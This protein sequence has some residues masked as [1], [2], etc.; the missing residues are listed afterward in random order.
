MTGIFTREAQISRL[1]SDDEPWDIVVIGGGATGVGVAADA[2]AR[3]YRV[4]LLEHYDFGKGTSS[5]ST[6]LVHGGLRYLKQGRIRLVRDALIERGLLC[7]NAPHLVYPL[8]TIVPLHS[9]WESLY[10]GIGLKVYERLSGRLSLGPSQR[11]SLDEMRRAIPTLE[12]RGLYG[13][14]RYLDGAFDDARLLVNLMQTAIEHGALCANY[15]PA[16]EL[17]KESG[18]VRGVVAEDLET[19]KATQLRAR[20]VVNA[21]GPFSDRILKLD[22]PSAR[23]VIAA[24]QGIHLVFD[25]EFLP[26]D[27]AIIVPKTRDGRVIF[28]VPWHEHAV[29]GTTDTPRADMPLE[30]RPLPG[31]VE[32]ILETI[33]PYLTHKPQMADIRSIFA[34]IRP[35]VRG[36]DASNTSKLGRDHEVRIAASELISV[37]GGKWTTYRKMAE[38]CVD[39]AARVAGLEKRA[40]TTKSMPVHGH[41]NHAPECRL[42]EYGSDAKALEQVIASIPSGNARLAERLPYVAGQVVFAARNEMARTVEDVLARRTRALFLDAEAAV[43][44]APRVAE[45]LAAELGRNAGWQTQQ[46]TQFL[47]VATAY[48]PQFSAALGEPRA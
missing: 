31:E 43:A 3:G 13:G 27:S 41:C 26:S 34:G 12:T 9:R 32:F 7:R 38:D 16:R 22:D 37:L 8:P 39:Q 44:A 25:R 15:A 30:P 21:T 47:D 18:K 5:R 4:A 28:A 11:L 48:R 29:I 36:G 17:I 24:S 14:A 35:L 40:C 10:Y 19:G 23:P 20:V 33:S 42:H 1:E 6:K 2:A 46:L 45:L